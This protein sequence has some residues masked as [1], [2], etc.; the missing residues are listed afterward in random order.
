M[1][2]I[3]ADTIA[4]DAATSTVSNDDKD[5]SAT[6]DAS[7]QSVNP[8]KTTTENATTKTFSATLAKA[9]P[10]ALR[11]QLILINKHTNEQT[12]GTDQKTDNF[13][14]SQKDT[15]VLE[16][17]P[18][19]DVTIERYMDG[20]PSKLNFKV[21]KDDELDFKEGNLVQFF[22]DGT[23]VFH[24][25]VFTKK[26]GKDQTIGVTCYDQMRYLKNK[27]CMVLSNMTVTDLVKQIAQD[28]GLTVGDVANTTYKIRYRVEDNKTLIDII[29][30]ALSETL[31]MTKEHLLYFLYDDAGKLTLQPLD[32][33]KLDL[34]LDEE[35]TQ[36]YDY[37]TSIDKDTYNV[38]KVV[39][40][41]PGQQG[42][43]LLRTGLIADEENIKEWGRLQYVMRPDNKDTI[44]MEQ[45]EHL[46]QLKDRKTRSVSLKGVLGDIRVRGGSLLYI[47][48]N[49][50]DLVL[51]TYYLVDQVTHR[52]T[53]G[54]HTMDIKLFYNEKL[55]NT[56]KVLQN[57]DAAVLKRIQEAEAKQRGAASGSTRTTSGSYS[58]NEVG[59]FSKL[60]SMGASN[61]QAIGV[62]ANVRCE[63]TSYDAKL[64]NSSGHTGLFQLSPERWQKYT[65]WCDQNYNDYY[66]NDNQ[67]E[68]V[69]K[70]EHG[71]L[72]STNN[73]FGEAMPED[74]SQA[75]KW[76]NDHI[77]ISETSA[78][79][80]G[81]SSDRIAQAADLEQGLANGSLYEE[82]ISYPAVNVD[83]SGAGTYDSSQVQAGFDAVLH[84]GSD[85]SPYSPVNG[86]EGCAETVLLELS[87]I[88]PACAT[89]SQNGVASVQGL[90][91]GMEGA[92]Y[93]VTPFDGYASCRKGDILIYHNRSHVVCYDGAGG[94]VGN[95]SSNCQAWH[96][97]D[98]NYAYSS[99]GEQPD[100]VI[101]I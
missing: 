5:V 94:A 68:Y 12:S 70:V 62:L 18:L 71:D 84:A 53:E 81:D 69:T 44:A 95:S 23:K 63:N 82:T 93:S 76:F 80:G 99:S 87:Y 35:Q 89:M 38:V 36:D 22:V 11:Y 85:G 19:D 60:K 55:S 65:E 39:R 50:G 21:L 73:D 25:F 45:A 79:N 78:A 47:H 59:G 3:D 1:A 33:M 75:A 72:F 52:F 46:I 83:T 97:S 14:R 77:E 34:Y 32:K 37:Q 42:K 92:G 30:Y 13:S 88:I 91:D 2:E 66:N 17:D 26:I 20:T 9:A 15:T 29:N 31:V 24:G 4:N 61:G 67:I 7:S 48:F 43:T 74:S 28:Y 27:D 57:D 6:A 56:Y 98:A 101:H 40:E 51:N 41:A 100:E 90:I 58:Q 49:L 64:S 8:E 10:F 96:Y 86:S 16:L 54:L